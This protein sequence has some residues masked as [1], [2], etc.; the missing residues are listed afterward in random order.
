MTQW[1]GKVGNITEQDPTR[2]SEIQGV[3]AP[4][5]GTADS[6]R[7][8]M[9]TNAILEKLS[10]DF[11]KE[12]GQ[13]VFYC[14][15][16]CLSKQNI[17]TNHPF[18]TQL[19]SKNVTAALYIMSAECK[20]QPFHTL[21]A[22][23]S[24]EDSVHIP[25]MEYIATHKSPPT[26]IWNPQT[27]QAV[28]LSGL[29]SLAAVAR[30]LGDPDFIGAAGKNI[31]YDW[32]GNGVSLV[33]SDPGVCF[34]L[35]PASRHNRAYCLF[36]KSGVTNPEVKDLQIANREER[37][38]FC[39]NALTAEQKEEFM[40]TLFHMRR[41]L[42][43][44]DRIDELFSL[45]TQEEG[46]A[47]LTSSLKKG[48]QDWLENQQTIYQQEFLAFEQQHAALVLRVQYID[49]FGDLS[50]LASNHKYPIREL[51]TPI[52]L[53][54]NRTASSA[55]ERDTILEAIQSMRENKSP[56]DPKY[57]F[58]HG[59]KTVLLIGS[60][61]T[62][63]STFC[64]KI[65]HDWAAGLLWQGQY[66]LV[67][68]IPL[69]AVNPLTDPGHSLAG[70]GALSIRQVLAI[71]I[72]EI[73]FGNGRASAQIET[74]LSTANPEKILIIL[75][76]YDEAKPAM[77]TVIDRCIQDKPF[78]LLLT[79]RPGAPDGLQVDRVVESAGFSDDE[80]QNY[81]H[82]Y[83]TIGHPKQA[84]ELQQGLFMA[85]KQDIHVQAVAHIPLHLQ[86]LCNLWE[87]KRALPSHTAQIYREMIDR[88][89]SWNR[90]RNSP[91][92]KRETL[93]RA[94][95]TIALRGLQGG[96][97]L[98]DR[99]AVADIAQEFGC[100]SLEELEK[101]GLLEKVGDAYQFLHLTFQEYLTAEWIS[102]KPSQEIKEF[103]VAHR[104]RPQFQ[105]IIAFLAGMIADQETS[106]HGP[107]KLMEFMEALHHAQGADMIGAYQLEL[108]LRCL[109]ECSSTQRN[110]VEKK[111]HV[112]EVLNKL[113]VFTV[114]NDNHG[115]G[116]D[117]VLQ[118]FHFFKIPDA[119]VHKA[120]DQ[121][122]TLV[123]KPFF[124]SPPASSPTQR[125]SAAQFLRSLVHKV[126]SNSWQSV[127]SALRG[128][129]EVAW[130]SFKGYQKNSIGPAA[131]RRALDQAQE[132]L[133]KA[134]P[135]VV[136]KL[137]LNQFAEQML[138][139]R[140]YTRAIE[141]ALE[142]MEE[143][144]KAAPDRWTEVFFTLTEMR[145]KW[146]SELGT[147]RVYGE[148]KEDL[149]H[150]C[151]LI[152]RSLDA[153]GQ[154]AIE[155]LGGLDKV[156]TLDSLTVCKGLAHW[157]QNEERHFELSNHPG[158]RNSQRYNDYF[159]LEIS[160]L[161]D[162]LG[163][164]TQK[165]WNEVFV[166]L[167]DWRTKF[168]KDTQMVRTLEALIQRTPPEKLQEVLALGAQD[169]FYNSARS[170]E[171]N[172]PDFCPKKWE[173]PDIRALHGFSARDY[174]NQ[175]KTL[176]SPDLCNEEFFRD[177]AERLLSDRTA[178]CIT[179][180]LPPNTYT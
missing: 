37:L 158:Y 9:N 95:G 20:H 134:S 67:F 57:L 132:Q 86:M 152:G 45:C 104:Y 149:Q 66:D 91:S 14:P 130:D 28:R 56:I 87:A 23:K 48:L 85:I 24:S 54:Y 179:V 162:R 90:D 74:T 109:N 159:Y 161:F 142:A 115:P 59:V 30:V 166:V 176:A 52:T 118:L 111:Y 41:Y 72:G 124:G 143:L 160:T 31:E 102:T 26:W 99:S 119:V 180:T 69:K 77:R 157:L 110:Q 82:Q 76:G 168:P 150:Q 60:A 1:T 92:V 29:L 34:H 103:V 46:L 6:I 17:H 173:K 47:S 97:L 151:N 154:A 147:L 4:I 10:C 167:K 127:F 55:N 112:Y 140:E 51:F 122:K 141:P 105:L 49:Q 156:D 38:V 101:T 131:Y 53:I 80:M 22:L 21:K 15:Q 62:G 174:D 114:L 171:W 83:F 128:V 16:T 155:V 177:L 71:A 108:T 50:L 123:C 93:R 75:D 138:G 116:M 136:Q 164:Q 121:V 96:N 148:A 44:K 11:Y 5:L 73:V 81:M 13:G 169:S 70:I 19:A 139:A 40:T 113:V 163:K 165:R 7:I 61:G 27:R 65:A 39:W 79:S 43:K 88:I 133:G 170:G 84:E 63:K 58:P 18:F 120:I 8:Q 129:A 42:N 32:N 98:V 12:F 145:A 153:L 178:L 36:Q 3:A 135:D 117:R 89:L 172:G 175:M 144:G 94:L 126:P 33:K 2:I 107:M 78:S 64:Q 35:F 146:L 125:A 25:I 68:R 137:V 106:S 100:P